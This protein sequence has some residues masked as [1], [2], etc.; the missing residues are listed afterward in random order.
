M[1]SV[2]LLDNIVEFWLYVWHI[3]RWICICD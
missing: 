2:P 1:L 3:F